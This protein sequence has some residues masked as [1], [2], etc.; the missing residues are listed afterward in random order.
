M[1]QDN[2]IFLPK[3]FTKDIDLNI[4]AIISLLCIEIF[5]HIIELVIDIG[6]LF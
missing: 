6:Q 3:I 4:K 2:F 5:I 1:K